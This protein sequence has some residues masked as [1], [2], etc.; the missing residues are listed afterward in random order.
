MRTHLSVLL[1][2]TTTAVARE[3]VVRK[4][5]IAT[6]WSM[7]LHRM[8]TATTTGISEVN[9]DRAKICSTEED[10]KHARGR[11]PSS[12]KKLSQ[13]ATPW[14]R[15]TAVHPLTGL[16]RHREDWERRRENGALGFA[17]R[18]PA[19]FC[20]PEIIVWPSNRNGWT[21]MNE[22]LCGPFASP[23]S[24]PKTSRGL[25]CRSAGAREWAAGCFH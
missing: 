14:S 15:S 23:I 16:A 2:M 24:W 20:S 8:E 12:G 13:L 21:M 6:D 9:R 4:A 19:V 10:P 1:P 11:E 22:P 7:L 17:R 18:E 25:G 3:E 5:P